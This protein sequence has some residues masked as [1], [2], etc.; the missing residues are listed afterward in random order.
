[1]NGQ[2]KS[3]QVAMKVNSHRIAAAGRA[4]GATTCHTTRICEH[5]SIRAASISSSGTA[6]TRYWRMKNTPNAVT[7]VGTMIDHV[8]PVQ[9]SFDIRMNSGTM[10]SCVGT[11]MVA[12][13]P[14][15]SADRPRKRSLAKA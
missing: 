9:P 10:P 11:A 3:V 14:A 12:T 7:S 8:V 13:T 6:S 15:S 4:A 5:P 1:M 2:K